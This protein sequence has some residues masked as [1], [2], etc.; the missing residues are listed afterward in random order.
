MHL[1]S[2]CESDLSG[3]AGRQVQNAEYGV[4]LAYHL[5]FRQEIAEEF[6]TATAGCGPFAAIDTRSRETLGMSFRPHFV[7]GQEHKS[8]V[9]DDLQRHAPHSVCTVESGVNSLEARF[10][11]LV[12]PLMRHLLKHAISILHSEDLAWDAVQEALLSLWAEV[13]NGGAVPDHA[14]PWLCRAVIYRSLHI[15]RTGNRRTKH[16][17]MACAAR[18]GF[19]QSEDP[20]RVVEDGELR[21]VLDLALARIPETYRQVFVL[22]ELQGLEYAQ[23]AVDLRIPVGTV[24]SRLSRAREQLQQILEQAIC[25]PADFTGTGSPVTES[26]SH[27][28]HLTTSSTAF[29]V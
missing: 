14:G 11:D 4:G 25:T 19:L 18:T 13:Q 15:A 22:R 23:I 12:T 2:D 16:E 20:A 7:C 6:H 27:Y 26:G 5:P 28:E 8:Q 24:R 9:S 21:E 10:A 3:G 17:H 29:N 1:Q